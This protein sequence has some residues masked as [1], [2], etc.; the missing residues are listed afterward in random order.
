LINNSIP[1]K[2][3]KTLS[4]RIVKA[5]EIRAQRPKMLKKAQ[6]QPKNG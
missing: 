1:D 5:I 6:K 4:N 3:G 2:N